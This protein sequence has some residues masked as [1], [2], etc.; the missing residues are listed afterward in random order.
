MRPD[1]IRD[2][3]ASIPFAAV[4]RL[5]TC[6][7]PRKPGWFGDQGATGSDFGRQQP[8]FFPGKGRD[9]G[10]NRGKQKKEEKSHSWGR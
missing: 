9:L 5:G 10:Q 7:M 1:E 6:W 3:M 2:E 8:P 4:E